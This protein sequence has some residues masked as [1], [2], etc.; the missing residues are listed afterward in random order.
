MIL[1]LAAGIP[2]APASATTI[3]HAGTL[4]AVADERPVSRYSIIIIR[5]GRIEEVRSGYIEGAAV[6]GGAEI[7]D[8]RNAFVLP[9][10][11]D[12]HT[13]ITAEW[14]DRRKMD[15]VT[16]S[17]ADR[18]LLGAEHARL[19]LGAGFTT[20][21]NLGAYRGG[22][23]DAIFALRDAIANGK[24][25]GPRI[26]AS[27]HVMTPTG[28]DADIHGFREDVMSHLASNGV[29]D[30]ADDCRRAVC[31][32]IKRGADVI[33]ITA[34]GGVLSNT[35]A[36]TDQQFTDD[37][38]QAIV[39][40]AH[41]L[42][43][44]VAA[45]AHGLD[46]IN[47]AFRAG[48]DSIEHGSFLDGSSIALFKQT[49]ADLVPTMMPPYVLLQAVKTSTPIPAAVRDKILAVGP[50][51][52]E[53][54]RRALKGGLKFGFGT[55][56]GAYPYGQNAKEFELLVEA[57]MSET[58]AIESA[59]VNA[60]DLV[61]LSHAVGTIEPGKAAD[62]IAV[63]KSPLQDITQLQR[64]IFVMRNGTVYKP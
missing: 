24:I 61:G 15:E 56:T 26:F 1:A 7:I 17:E 50:R 39:D 52:N 36:V 14:G 3:I 9:G 43:R 48:V 16:T 30:G 35:A 53:V 25:P 55:D 10:L 27:G 29:C 44:K 13:H 63:S 62:I 59:T 6:S 20:V 8:L 40:T 23:G 34:T 64:V 32:Q 60:A 22:S 19:I 57:G 41:A 47:A 54:I 18:A 42:G 12:L 38:L 51:K 2:A 31:L 4:L 28:G 58:D 46:G 5:D 37:E 33:K 11:I 49:G 45:H 21:R